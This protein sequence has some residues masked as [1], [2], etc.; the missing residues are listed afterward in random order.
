MG[1]RRELG[2]SDI[3]NPDLY[4]AESLTAKPLAV[5]ADTVAG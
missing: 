1:L 5:L 2:G 4:W 3:G